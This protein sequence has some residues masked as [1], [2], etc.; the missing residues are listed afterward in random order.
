[1][2]NK[3]TIEVNVTYKCKVEIEE[4]NPIVKAYESENDL[5]VHCAF[6]RFQKRMPVIKDGGVKVTAAELIDVH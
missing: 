3:K 2:A 4:D 5:L 6:N 1:M